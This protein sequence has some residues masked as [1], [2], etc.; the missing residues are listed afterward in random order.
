MDPSELFGELVLMYFSQVTMEDTERCKRLA[1]EREKRI[2]ELQKELVKRRKLSL[3]PRGPYPFSTL[4]A[5][6][7][8]TKVSIGPRELGYEAQKLKPTI[9]QITRT[10]RKRLCFVHVVDHDLT[11]PHH[12]IL[13][14]V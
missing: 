11:D 4:R 8:N 5:V 3:E 12:V 1:L 7:N 13:F 2:G 14:V 6:E 9:R 10:S